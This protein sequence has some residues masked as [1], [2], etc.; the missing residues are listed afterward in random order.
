MQ[1]PNNLFSMLH[2]TCNFAI[3]SSLTTKECKST[4][5][6]KIQPRTAV[7]RFIGLYIGK[8]VALLGTL[9]GVTILMGA[10]IFGD[11][12]KDIGSSG[13]SPDGSPVV[14]E[15]VD[16]SIVFAL[17]GFFDGGTLFG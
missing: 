6:A 9:V 10:Q 8:L 3:A 17:V 13:G 2:R 12:G 1:S 4:I 16:I 5:F 11:V 7:F 14:G 15:Y